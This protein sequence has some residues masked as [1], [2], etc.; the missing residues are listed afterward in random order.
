MRLKTII[1]LMIST[2]VF[3]TV[4]SMAQDTFH[5]ATNGSDTTGNGTNLAPWATI[6]HALDTVTDGSL[7]LVKPGT[8]HG[9]IRLRGT[10][11]LGVTVRSEIPYQARLRHNDTVITAYQSASGVRG[12]TIEGFDIAH[13]GIGAGALVVHIDGGGNQEVTHLTLQNNI[14]HDSYNNDILKIN[15]ATSNIVVQE[16]MFYNQ[17]GSD[18]H[19]DINS[20]DNVVVK[21]NIFFN[22][23]SGSGRTNNNTTSSFIVIKDSNGSNDIYT[24][25]RNVILAQNIFLNWE[26]SSGSNFILIGEDGHPYFEGFNITVENNLL[27]G[28]ATNVMRSPFGV[29]GGRDIIFRNNTLSGDMPSMAFAMRLNREGNNPANQNIQ[30]YNNIFSDPTTTMGAENSTRPNDFSDTPPSDTLSF[31]LDH[32]LFWNGGSAIPYNSSE[33]INYTHDANRVTTSPQLLPPS[34]IFPPRWNQNKGTFADNSQSI[35]AVF[36]GLANL[37]CTLSPGSGA[38]NSGE[39]NQT[40]SLDLLGQTRGSAP[41]IGACEYTSSGG[42]GGNGGGNT[43][44]TGVIAPQLILLL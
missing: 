35:E 42:G 8:Y 33:L 20:V 19:I 41:D 6:T 36:S 25:S 39:P 14:L 38:I 29:K 26:G 28:N 12:I 34:S 10:F 1:F 27:L 4:P 23:F 15:N 18:E 43:G 32:N 30:F 31:T 9:R 44:K 5:I 13:S 21:G 7:I 2:M 3:G 24:G 16:N 37:Y 22:D 17:T 11:P 40:P